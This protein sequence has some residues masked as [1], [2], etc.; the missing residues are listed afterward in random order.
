MRKERVVEG[1]VAGA[2]KGGEILG[3]LLLQAWQIGVK[4]AEQMRPDPRA[5]LPAAETAD[6]R[7]LKIS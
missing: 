4:L 6:A 1:H 2:E 5:G 7:F 3:R